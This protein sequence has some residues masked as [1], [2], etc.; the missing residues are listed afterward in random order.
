MGIIGSVFRLCGLG[1]IGDVVDSVGADN[2]IKDKAVD[3]AKDKAVDY[4]KDK[5][6]NTAK[7]KVLGFVKKKMSDLGK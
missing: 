7:G 5:A 6:I 1:V 4:A 2:L 3:Y